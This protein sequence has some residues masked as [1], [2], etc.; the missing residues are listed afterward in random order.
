M[1]K[2]FTLGKCHNSL[3]NVNNKE[4]SHLYKAAI[5]WMFWCLCDSKDDIKKSEVA[6]KPKWHIGRPC[7]IY[8]QIFCLFDVNLGI[9]N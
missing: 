1:V 3:S 5:W 9:H 7:F 2:S 4:L 6:S 8:F